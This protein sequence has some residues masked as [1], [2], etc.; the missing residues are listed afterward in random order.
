[1][2][3]VL[4]DANF[5]VA[6]LDPKDVWHQ[7]AKKIDNAIPDSVIRLFTDIVVI[8]S[9]SVIARRVNERK[10]QQSFPALFSTLRSVVPAE[11][12]VWLSPHIPY[13]Y[14]TIF[15]MMLSKSGEL[16]FN[17]C[18]LVVFM[19][20]ADIHNIVSFDKDFDSIPTIQRISSA[21]QL[22]T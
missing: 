1:M 20:E 15:E 22:R 7:H 9:I 2:N 10:E 6:L 4:I 5:L 14:N 21:E 11:K 19:N 8:E 18:L 3:R 17:D 13:W 12:I 16:N